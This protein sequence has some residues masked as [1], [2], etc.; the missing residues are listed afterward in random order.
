VVERLAT[1][2][3]IQIDW[4]PFYLRPDTPPEG[5]ELPAYVRARM[6]S[7]H[8]RLKQ[9]ARAAGMDMVFPTRIPNTRFAH[10]AA[11]YA[12]ANGKHLE[13]HRILF[14]LYY[15]EGQDISSWNVLRAAAQEAG[16]D[17]KE[18]ER[19]VERGKYTAAVEEQ[20]IEAQEIGISGVPTYILN[21]TY[22]IVGAQPYE[23]FERAL[24][25]LAD[26]VVGPKED[27]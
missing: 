24:A 26:E 23:V 5:S 8:A 17:P 12:R 19:E 9:M 25:R 2:R 10:E 18:M 15:G 16:L 21:N 27:S 1:E 7:A 20:I 13:F 3:E 14:R 4:R 6:A 11:E 22:A